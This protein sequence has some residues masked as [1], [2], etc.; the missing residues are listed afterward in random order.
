MTI[1]ILVIAGPTAVG[2][3]RIAIE[4]AKEL[5]GEIISADSR[6]IYKGV[7][8]GAAKPSKDE[9]AAVKHHMLNVVN[10]DESFSVGEYKRSSEKI[11]EDIWQRNRL[12]IIAGGTGLYIRAVIDGLWEGPKADK[13]LRDKLKKEEEAFGNGHLYNKLKEVDP[14]TAEKTKPND[15]VR[16]IRSLEVYYK[17]G[18]PI[19]YFHRLHGFQ[20][21]NY[22]VMLIGL[23][24]ERGR[25]YKKIEERVDEMINSGLIDEVKCLLK[26]GYD[27]NISSMTGVG[28]RQ[29]IGYLRGDYNLE[30]AVRL[31][32]RDTKRYAKRQYTWFNKDKR[33]EWFSID[34]IDIKG[35]A[36][37][38]KKRLKL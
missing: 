3:T 4:L 35:L 6:Q 20:E 2:K 26:K 11:I 34:D 8:I 37:S 12:P 14:E 33:I 21:K 17:E 7:D 19:S 15:L 9:Q 30:E 5:N 13:E 25:L 23:T 24:M 36:P 10:P 32:K 28:Y 29:V 38:I 27:E 1:P 31:I 16:I 18:K 22:N